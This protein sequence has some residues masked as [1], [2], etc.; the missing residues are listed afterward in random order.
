MNVDSMFEIKSLFQPNVRPRVQQIRREYLLARPRLHIE[1]EIHH[2]LAN[3]RIQDRSEQ[4][5]QRGSHGLLPMA[6]ELMM[7]HSG[8]SARTTVTDDNP[9]KHSWKCSFHNTMV[10][11]L[12]NI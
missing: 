12:S 5:C 10:V 11:T 4:Y 1:V 2:C 3:S 9:D 8:S 7:I 6:V